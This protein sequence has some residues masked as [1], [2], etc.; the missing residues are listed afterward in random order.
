[1]LEFEK[2]E[3]EVVIIDSKTRGEH[4]LNI[5]EDLKVDED[6]LNES[7]IEQSSKYAWYGAIYSQV[8]QQYE[9]LKAQLGD[10]EASVDRRIREDADFEGKKKPA[11]T[12]M[13]RYVH[14][15]K[16][17]I[18]FIEKINEARRK[19]DLINYVL[20]AFE[21]RISVLITLGANIRNEQKQ[22]GIDTIK[23]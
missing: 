7:L 8:K 5:N 16:E 22:F 18:K 19:V 12:A 17:Y 14:G 21:Q 4:I 20:T 11:E 3:L 15:D 13:V 6:N 23:E 9:D 1:M 10:V 2:P